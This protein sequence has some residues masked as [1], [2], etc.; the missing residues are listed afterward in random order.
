MTVLEKASSNLTDPLAA[1][2]G[3]NFA[4]MRRSLGRYSS[5]CGLRPRSKT[6]VYSATAGLLRNG[7]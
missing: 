5:L 1:E 6:E 3:S 2:V 7:F 4:E